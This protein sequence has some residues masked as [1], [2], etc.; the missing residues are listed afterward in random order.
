LVQ[1]AQRGVVDALEDGA[2]D[3]VDPA[4]HDRPLGVARLGARDEGMGEHDAAHALTGGQ[5]TSDELARRA[6]DRL[7]RP[8]QR[9]ARAGQRNSRVVGVEVGD[10]VDRCPHP[11]AALEQQG[12]VEGAEVGDHPDAVAEEG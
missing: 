1:V 6:D 2:R 8:R 10:A 5:V 9:P 3:P 12:Q 4:D 11:V 7:V